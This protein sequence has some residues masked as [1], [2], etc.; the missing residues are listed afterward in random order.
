MKSINIL[1]SSILNQ[2]CVK[3]LEMHHN[4]P[5]NIKAY[6]NHFDK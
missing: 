5:N 1:K 4:A 6:Q 2:T 3:S